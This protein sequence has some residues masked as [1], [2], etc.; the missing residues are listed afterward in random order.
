MRFKSKEESEKWGRAQARRAL[1]FHRGETVLFFSSHRS[2]TSRRALHCRGALRN[3]KT[4]KRVSY[5][6]RRGGHEG[7]SE[8]EGDEIGGP[9]LVLV[10]GEVRAPGK[11]KKEREWRESQNIGRGE[12]KKQE[13][14]CKKTRGRGVRYTIKVDRTAPRKMWLAGRFPSAAG[15]S[16]EE[17]AVGHAR[18]RGALF[19][20]PRLR[21]KRKKRSK[22]EGKRSSR[23]RGAHLL[24]FNG[25]R[26]TVSVPAPP[27]N[28][29][30]SLCRWLAPARLRRQCFCPARCC[31][32]R[33]VL[34]R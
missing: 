24:F 15:S 13:V 10:V 22:K 1:N 26:K 32:S 31:F 7:S 27:L 12:R 16:G 18:G 6:G 30:S 11:P 8:E 2:S 29:L 9:H 4:I 25:L 34:L 28:S 17:A 3:A 14:D 19:L 21:E 33:R 5:Q 23:T 20:V